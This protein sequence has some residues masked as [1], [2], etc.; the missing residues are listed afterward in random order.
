MYEVKP[1]KSIRQLYDE[2]GNAY[3]PLNASGAIM[4]DLSSLNLGNIK[5]VVNLSYCL[6]LNFLGGTFTVSSINN[7]FFFYEVNCTYGTAGASIPIDEELIVASN[8]PDNYRI[9][10]AI[11][12]MSADSGMN[13]SISIYVDE[14][15]TMKAKVLPL[16]R[17]DIGEDKYQSSIKAI[18]AS[19]FFV[20]HQANGSNEKDKYRSTVEFLLSKPFPEDTIL[21]F[22]FKSDREYKV[23]S[24]NDIGYIVSADFFEADNRLV[25]AEI[26]IP[27]QAVMIKISGEFK[28]IN[29]PEAINITAIKVGNMPSLVEFSYLGYTEGKQIGKQI[30]S[31]LEF[32]MGTNSISDMSAMFYNCSILKTIHELNTSS[33]TTLYQAFCYCHIL[34]SIPASFNTDKVTN[35]KEAFYGC[36]LL[37]KAPLMNTSGVTN[38]NLMFGYASKLKSVPDYDYS[39]VQN[40]S[41]M[42]YA[43]DSLKSIGSFNTPK[44]TNFERMFQ[45]CTSL[46]KVEYINLQK[47]ETIYGLI[48]GCSKL[49]SIHMDNLTQEYDFKPNKKLKTESIDYLL[50]NI[51]DPATTDLIIDIN[52]VEGAS[53]VYTGDWNV[54]QAIDRGW[55]II[56]ANAPAITLTMDRIT[57]AH[58]VAINGA[59]DYKYTLE[60]VNSNGVVLSHVDCEASV[61]P[62]TNALPVPTGTEKIIVRGSMVI[63][64]YPIDIAIKT[65]DIENMPM[66]ANISTMG[67]PS[68]KYDPCRQSTTL[69][70]F[71]LRQNNITNM[72]NMFYG[73][74]QLTS[75]PELYTNNAT[76]MENMFYG[77][78]G[79]GTI[80]KLNTSKVT[81]MSKMF[82][83][84]TSL[85]T[86]PEID[87][88]AVGDMSYMFDHCS[89]LNSIPN[90]NAISATSMAYM[91]HY[92]NYLKTIGKITTSVKLLNTENMFNYC[93]NLVSVQEF[94]TS[95]VT[96]AS[97]MFS[98]CNRITSIPELDMSFVENAESMFASCNAL[99][100]TPPLDLRRSTSTRWMFSYCRSLSSIGKLQTGNVTNMEN[101]FREC[102]NLVTIP[103]MD[104]SK[105]T[106]MKEMFYKCT[107]LIS[108]P[109][110]LDIRRVTNMENMFRDCSSLTNIP[111][112]ISQTGNVTSMRYM[113][114]GCT[115]LTSIDDGM[116]N[117]KCT[118][119]SYMFQNCKEASGMFTIKNL[120]S[121]KV[122]GIFQETSK[123]IIFKY[124]STN[125]AAVS[126]SAPSNVTK[127]VMA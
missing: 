71:T 29:Y 87:V 99:K 77:C 18:K 107:N 39:Q 116:E 2:E 83:N 54:L 88:S 11:I 93:Q 3:Y 122:D 117:G 33:A 106:S 35:M 43:C 118:D 115:S 65:I 123:R 46:L 1:I 120:N 45:N 112:N 92:C 21:T 52:G 40:T 58:T 41:Y 108:I 25:T 6:S 17:T 84:C 103:N 114:A 57:T 67:Q 96:K 27:K 94:D 23:E 86:I 64:Q 63:F 53:D 56:G 91:F 13:D 73:C 31:L 74:N 105:V 126:Y 81:N 16:G 98:N 60:T 125:T 119:F 38:M 5:K 32:S 76:T 110:T 61:L 42:F 47:A 121:T 113:F 10:G 70:K 9:N 7:M 55:T 109:P 66:L 104:V 14:N 30:P 20:K 50:D 68:G 124:Y 97:Y 44:C 51:S 75:I 26:K 48:D 62:V 34:E 59:S 37:E 82:S 19:G 15:G 85:I 79:L 72:S 8:I 12:P 49:E 111:I 28:V 100:T 80:P 78:T 101:M 127:Q 102:T 4:G 36:T 24:I 90:L 95:K 22:K 69:T 89:S